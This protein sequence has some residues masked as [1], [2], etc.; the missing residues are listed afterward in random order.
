M[1][2]PKIIVCKNCKNRMPAHME[3]CNY[4][5]R[6]ISDEDRAADDERKN[7]QGKKDGN[8]CK[9]CGSSMAAEDKYCRNC[10]AAA[11]EEYSPASSMKDV[12]LLYG[13]PWVFGDGKDE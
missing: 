9:N 2:N 11:G 13:P 10:G 8:V 5:G 6:K 3:S 1:N 7:S 12:Q 4:C